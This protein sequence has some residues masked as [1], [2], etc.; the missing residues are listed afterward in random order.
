MLNVK[1]HPDPPEGLQVLNVTYN[2]VFLTWE[3]GFNGGF[4]QYFRIRMKKR[5]AENYVYVDVYPHNVSKFQL[6]DLQIGTTYSFNIMAFN[7]L[8]D[9]NYTTDNVVAT[10]SSK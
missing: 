7:K 2:S 3:H 10:T 6:G 4:E 8:G 9:S 1:S 5:D